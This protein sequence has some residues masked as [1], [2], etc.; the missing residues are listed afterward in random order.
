MSTPREDV[1]IHDDSHLLSADLPA[2]AGVVRVLTLNRPWRRNAL[3]TALLQDLVAALESADQNDDVRAVVVTGSGAM[4]C[5]GGDVKEFVG[6]SDARERMI[7][8]AQLLTRL[9]TLL[10][11]MST[12]VAAAVNGAALGA[13]AALALAADLVIAGRDAVLG[14]PEITDSVVP[15][16]VMAGA[17]RHL[18]QKLAFQMLTQGRRL[19]ATESLTHGLVTTVVTPDR[20]L[21]ATVEAALT[22]AQVEPGAL[23]ETKRLFYRVA[24]LDLEAGVRAGLDVTAATWNPR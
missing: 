16:V 21:D 24:E 6:H 10:P 15:A 9:L 1:P 3:N 19:D 14:Y 17:V 4:F 22:W 8:R 18:G 7:E 23:S 12:P 13:G 20:T 2:P 5:A 11:A